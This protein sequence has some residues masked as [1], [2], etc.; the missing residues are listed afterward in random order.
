MTV[1]ANIWSYVA[2]ISRS[3]E[4]IAKRGAFDLYSLPDIDMV[5]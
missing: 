4:R 1:K 2:G 3:F 5:I